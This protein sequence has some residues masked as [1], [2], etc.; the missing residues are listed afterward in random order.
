VAYA[1]MATEQTENYMFVLQFIRT[2]FDTQ[3]FPNVIVTD[4]DLALIKAVAQVFPESKHH[5]CHRHVEVCVYTKALA[6][7][8][9]EAKFAEG[10]K[11]NWNWVIHGRT[12]EI[13]LY[14]WNELNDKYKGWPALLSY[15]YDVWL[16]HYADKICSYS[17]DT[18]LHYGSYTT[19]R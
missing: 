11:F 13:F 5:L 3:P 8:G 10:F 19:N 14:R 4:R 16:Q 15:C 1:F 7:P 17:I 12:E 2:L 6:Q 18:Y 9:F